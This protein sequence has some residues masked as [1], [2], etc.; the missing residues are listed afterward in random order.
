MSLSLLEHKIYHG[1]RVFSKGKA[2]G[3][4]FNSLNIDYSTRLGGN[5]IVG[6]G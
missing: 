6:I 5:F 2:S 1:T 4:N 3:P